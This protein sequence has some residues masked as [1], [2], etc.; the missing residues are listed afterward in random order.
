[1]RNAVQSLTDFGDAALLIPITIMVLLCLL[2]GRARRTAV[3]W[4]CAVSLCCVVMIVL[5][6]A[7]RSCGQILSGGTIWSPSGHTAFAATVYGSFLVLLYW[8]VSLPWLRTALMLL[9]IAW[10]TAIGIS[11]VILHTHVP[12]EVFIGFAVGGVCVVIFYRLAK[13]AEHLP[14][15][16]IGISFLILVFAL[17]GKR[18]QA[19]TIIVRIAHTL[20]HG[21]ASSCS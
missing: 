19:E 1:M 14:L 5:K 6:L 12:A 8:R 4:A 9:G 16:T 7:F 18:S 11:R 20:R 10:I 17:H 3:A 15:V 2:A 21:I 13:E